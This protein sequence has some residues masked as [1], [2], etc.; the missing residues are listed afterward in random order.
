[1][2]DFKIKIIDDIAIVAVDMLVATHRN[3]K[4]LWNELENKSILEWSKVIIDISNCIFID[5][6]F[7]GMIVKI[8]RRVMKNNGQVKL[9][10]P[11]QNA[12]KYLYTMGI[13]RMLECFNDL[14]QAVNSFDTEIPTRKI[15]FSEEITTELS[16]K[17]KKFKLK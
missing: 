1:L 10:Y 17:P 9:V 6:T 2:D 8:H 12:L 11:E 4:P 13:V 16:D 15:A 7:L 3:A 14:N 5:S